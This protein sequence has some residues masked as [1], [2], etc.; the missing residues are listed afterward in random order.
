[1]TSLA[2]KIASRRVALC[3]ME[4]ARCG[5]SKLNSHKL[6]KEIMMIYKK[7]FKKNPLVICLLVGIAIGIL[8]C[9]EDIGYE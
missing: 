7:P 6:H 3:G 8:R 9:S 2:K 4:L 1:M 5:I